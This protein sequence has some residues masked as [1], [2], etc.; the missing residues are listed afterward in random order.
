[1]NKE[2]LKLLAVSAGVFGIVVAANVVA[3]A[4]YTNSKLGVDKKALLIA[5]IGGVGL[6]FAVMKYYK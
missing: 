6:S 5:G 3:K 2:T 1:M 4:I